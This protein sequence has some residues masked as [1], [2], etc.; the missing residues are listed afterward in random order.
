MLLNRITHV[1]STVNKGKIDIEWER[2]K[3][4][5]SIIQKS[6]KRS[7]L[8][9]LAERRKDFVRKNFQVL[10]RV[11]RQSLDVAGIHTLSLMDTLHPS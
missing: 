11:Y 9:T 8:M 2:I 5:R 10:P 3:H 7:D 4:Y 6:A 1:Q